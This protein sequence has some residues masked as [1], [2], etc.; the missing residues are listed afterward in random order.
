MTILFAANEDLAFLRSGAST[1]MQTRAG[2]F[3]TLSCRGSIFLWEARRFEAT[4]DSAVSTLWWQGRFWYE[5][6]NNDNHD[7]PII[8]F[9]K[10]AIEILRVRH[11]ASTS[12]AVEVER[13]DGTWTQIIDTAIAFPSAVMFRLTIKLVLHASTGSFEMWLDET[14]IG[15]FSGDTL[16]T[17]GVTDCDGF[18]LESSNNGSNTQLRIY[19]TE[20]MVDTVDPTAKR[21]VTL[22]PT[23][24]GN[25]TA[26]NGGFADID[27]LELDDTDL[28]SSG[29]V[30]QV[31]NYVAANLNAAWAEYFAED[32]RVTA[33]AL[34]SAGGPQN[35]Q[36]HLR[37]NAT[38]Y[39]SSTKALGLAFAPVTASWTT[40]PDTAAAWTNAAVDALQYGVKSIT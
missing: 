35:I 34:R 10:G 13:N 40:D 17:S 3:D 36:L 16:G 6:G 39:F 37:S 21:L 29:T 18:V 14:K 30:D 15:D 5:V 28:I 27:E 8:I 38:N 25:D 33:R 20:V 2:T 19:L 31:E 12:S 1:Y 11:K 26:W 24:D 23:A 32:V 4:M 9:R 22:E 7:D